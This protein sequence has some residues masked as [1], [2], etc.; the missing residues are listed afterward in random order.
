MCVNCI[1]Q[2]FVV[3]SLKLK[4]NEVLLS[5]ALSQLSPVDDRPTLTKDT[6]LSIGKPTFQLSTFH[7]A[8]SSR[9]VDGVENADFRGGSCT[10]T[11]FNSRFHYSFSPWWAVDLKQAKKVTGV[12]I[13]TR[14]DCCHTRLRN[15]EIRLGNTKPD[16]TGNQNK[17]CATGSTIPQGK[18]YQFECKGRGRYVSV[19]IPGRRAILTL[20]EVEVL[21]KSTAFAHT[22]P[23]TN[24]HLLAEYCLIYV[25]HNFFS[26]KTLCVCYNH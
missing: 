5:M 3:I 7:D 13:T 23:F 22:K 11:G 8:V 6:V 20:C 21:G 17:V 9:A 15:F 14:S 25:L 10:R 26:C 12:R 19:G 1:S 16:G 18:T 2:V 4:L 24:L